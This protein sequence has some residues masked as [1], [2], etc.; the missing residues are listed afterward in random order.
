MVLLGTG[1]VGAPNPP[2]ALGDEAS[3]GTAGS[4]ME[5]SAPAE[6][7]E[8]A[9]TASDAES[10][11]GVCG[12][13]ILDPG[14][15][16]DGSD[17]GAQTCA[18]QGYVAGPLVCAP[19]CTF[20]TTHCLRCGNDIV[21]SDDEEC[22]GSDIQGG[23]CMEHGFASGVL[24]CDSSCRLDTSGCD[25][26]GNGEVDPGEDCE[27]HACLDDGECDPGAP[28]CVAGACHDGS[29]GD[30]CTSD[31]QCPTLLCGPSSCQGG[32]EGDPCRGSE[33]CS[34]AAPYCPLDGQCHDGSTGDP[35]TDDSQCASGN[36]SAAFMLCVF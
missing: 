1:C 30:P 27:G 16:C 7:T 25:P 35:C 13:G 5:T 17:L 33:D 12:D 11:G 21:D 22:D 31:A 2:A 32:S 29:A 28:F 15:S 34:D 6:T 3:T 36:C 8:G 10:D 20:D 19:S 24:A 23:T 26:C 14:E 9:D 18:S 4:G